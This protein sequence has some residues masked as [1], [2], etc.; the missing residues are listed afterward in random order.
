[1]NATTTPSRLDSIPAELRESRRWLVWRYVPSKGLK[2]KKKP[3]GAKVNNSATW[4]TFEGAVAAMTSKKADGIGFVLG[5]GF[6]GIDLDEC[7]A[8]NG[9][10]H[11]MARELLTLGTYV[12][13]SPGGHGLHAFARGTIRKCHNIHGRPGVPGHEIYDGRDG[14]ARFFT[15]TGDRVGDV[16]I[17]RRGLQAQTALDKFVA[18]WFQDAPKIAATTCAEKSTGGT[19]DDNDILRLMFDGNGEK[20]RT[21]FLGNWS[22][23]GYLSHSEADFGLCRKLRFYTRDRA[24]VDR[25]FRRSGLMRPKWDEMRG[26]QTYGAGTIAKAIAMGGPVY[27]RRDN[28]AHDDWK[29]AAWGQVPFWW[30]ARLKGCH[31]LTVRLVITLAAYADKNGRCYPSVPTLAA[32]LAV[33]ERQVWKA[34]DRLEAANIVRRTRRYNN[35][36]IYHLAKT[37]SPGT[38]LMLPEGVQTPC[39]DTN[40]LTHQ[41]IDTWGRGEGEFSKVIKSRT[42]LPK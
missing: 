27:V 1:M 30:V 10:L 37:L 41:D 5:D 38:P 42:R 21:A 15:V 11:E 4:L 39:L 25:L 18:K 22:V 7:I 23:A 17:V 28:T 40:V 14:S 31:E 20:W 29:R 8:A 13:K 6:V 32:D 16:A 9:T 19:L 3:L 2:P 36:N 34:L 24:Q 33:T 35:S 26:A 12:E